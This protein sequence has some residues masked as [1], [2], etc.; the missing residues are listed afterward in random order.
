[1]EW[2][3]WRIGSEV[4]EEIPEEH[5][6]PY[7]VEADYAGG[8]M[9]V[10]LLKS[11]DEFAAC[12]SIEIDEGVP[13]IHVSNQTSDENLVDIRITPE[14]VMFRPCNYKHAVDIL[15]DA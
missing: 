12:I 4:D 11:G 8:Q 6:I 9:S 13:T 2:K 1:M 7:R 10:S 15:E 3:D 14:G 5:Q